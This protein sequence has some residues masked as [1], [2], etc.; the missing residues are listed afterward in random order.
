MTTCR[1]PT[2]KWHTD[3]AEDICHECEEMFVKVYTK[4]FMAGAQ[5][6]LNGEEPK[7]TKKGG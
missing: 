3:T 1:N 5:F 7:L 6:V 4:G 2:C